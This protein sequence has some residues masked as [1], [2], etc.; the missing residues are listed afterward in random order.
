M[1]TLRPFMLLATTIVATATATADASPFKDFYVSVDGRSDQTGTYSAHQNPNFGRLTLLWAHPLPTGYNSTG[2][3]SNHYHRIGAIAHTGSAA[4]PSTTFFN[5]NIPEW[6]GTSPP[7]QNRFLRVAPGTG[8]FANRWVVADMPDAAVAD[9]SYYDNLTFA[10]VHQQEAEAL[11]DT[12]LVG[13]NPHGGGMNAAGTGTLPAVAA[14][15]RDPNGTF[16]WST[17]SLDANNRASTPIGWMYSSSAYAV[18]GSNPA[19][20]ESRFTRYF[21]EAQ[22]ALQL[23]SRD[24]KLKIFTT[25]GSQILDTAGSTQLLGTGRSWEFTPVFAVDNADFLEGETLTATFRLV[26]LNSLNPL[27]SSGDFTFFVAVPEPSTMALAAIGGI[28][29]LGMFSRRRRA[30]G[31]R[32]AS[33]AG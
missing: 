21:D 33:L 22:V 29:G 9:H 2:P 11:A 6:N 19:R 3:S 15:T 18:P 5:R 16:V 26:D 12:R 31:K 1:K 23:V 24:P 30:G 32:Q 13:G 17:G 25:A 28:A 10:S 20:V 4:S 7:A 14:P 27:G 8:A